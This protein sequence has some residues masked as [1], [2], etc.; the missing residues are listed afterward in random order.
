MCD[1]IIYTDWS[2]DNF[3]KAIVS[4]V[5][6]TNVPKK[7]GIELLKNSPGVKLQEG[8][9]KPNEPCP[10]GSGKKYKK[11]CALRLNLYASLE[12]GSFFC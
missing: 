2:K 4:I 5:G 9:I 12:E 11:C 3:F 1:N 8:N 10:C 7:I 6:K